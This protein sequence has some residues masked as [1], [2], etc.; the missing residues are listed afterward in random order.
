MS[1]CLKHREEVD[2][3]WQELALLSVWVESRKRLSEVVWRWA[4]RAGLRC[5][6]D[7]TQKGSGVGKAECTTETRADEVDGAV[8]ARSTSQDNLR[9]RLSPIPVL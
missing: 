5:D 8:T 6:R 3:V 4:T 7:V 1:I 2:R 9:N